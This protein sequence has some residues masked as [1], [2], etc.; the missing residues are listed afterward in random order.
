MKNEILIFGKGYFGSRIKEDLG[1]EV[2]EKKISSLVDVEEEVKKYRPKVII[3]CIGFIGRNVDDCEMNK[4]KAL[5]A[6]AFLPVIL[7]EV[8]LRNKIRLIHISTGCIYHYDYAKDSPIDEEKEP[9][10]FELYYSRTK[11]YAEQ[12]LRFLS[13]KCHILILR[14]RVPLDNR[15]N[16]KNL[17]TKLIATKK[18]ITLPNS[19]TYI[20]DFIQALKHL[21]K[22]EA[23]GIYNVV[24]KNPLSYP[25]LMEAYKKYVPGFEYQTIDFNKLNLI[26]T[27]IVLSTKKLE[28]TGFK[29]RDIKD[30][31]EECVK[32]YVKY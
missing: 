19:C 5:F 1:I 27:N 32:E 6:N 23:Q 7:G 18:V 3:N 25:D 30:I 24:N 11:I 29:A 10:F 14:P 21:I 26:R 9:D 4:E 17:L 20:P 31:L 22:I 8:C 2:S 12:V 13:K 28:D 15:P 16:P